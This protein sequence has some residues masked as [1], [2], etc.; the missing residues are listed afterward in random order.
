MKQLFIS[1]NASTLFF[2]ESSSFD[3]IFEWVQERV[4][5]DK[6]NI[7]NLNEPHSCSVNNGLDGSIWISGDEDSITINIESITPIL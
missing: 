6:S 3:D 2:S 1:G 4:M 7:F 5:F